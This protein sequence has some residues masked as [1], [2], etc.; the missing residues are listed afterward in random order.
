[1]LQN[2]IL[3]GENFFYVLLETNAIKSFKGHKKRLKLKFKCDFLNFNS[4]IKYKKSPNLF[5]NKQCIVLHF[6]LDVH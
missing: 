2:Q 4:K 1:M 5:L 6:Y 3:K